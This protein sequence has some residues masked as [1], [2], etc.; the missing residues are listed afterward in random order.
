MLGH[1]SALVSLPKQS[2]S[3]RLNGV[4]D[5]ERCFVVLSF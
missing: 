5:E 1:F 3:N 2:E 4:V